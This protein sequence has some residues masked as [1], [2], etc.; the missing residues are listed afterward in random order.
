[1]LKR[2]AILLL[3]ST[4]ALAEEPAAAT[5]SA[6]AAVPGRF[7]IGALDR[8][9]D[10]CVDFYQFACGGWRKANP[11]P[12][13]QTRWGRF[14]ELAERNR[15]ALHEIL[16]QAK[17]ARR[18][19]QRPRGQGG[20]LL[21]RVHGRGGHRGAR[22]EADRARSSSAVDAI[23]SKDEL[24][25]AARRERRRRRF[26][27][28]SA[29]ARRRTCTTPSRP[30]P[31][32]ARAASACRTATTTSKDDA[33]S[34]EKREK[35]VGARRQDAAAP[36]RERRKRQAKARRADGAPHRDGAW[37]RRTSTAWRCA[38]PK[39]RDNG[40]E[41]RRA[42]A[43]RARLRLGRLPGRHRRAGASRAST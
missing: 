11:I 9:V 23:A 43:A 38:I 36:R 42:E 22:H 35:Y 13:D 39:N 7:D 37:P 24:F 16:E 33:K 10:P 17:D 18:R 6:T 8:S 1:M 21:R 41:P 32:W 30:S 5:K 28:S 31:A 29:S 40:D 34:K 14:N 2:T 19:A 15:N 25:R 12:P 26:P 20:G 4:A 3:V 27:R